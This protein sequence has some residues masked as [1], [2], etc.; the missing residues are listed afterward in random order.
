MRIINK[1]LLYVLESRNLLPEQQYSF[2]NGRSTT[3]ALVI[4]QNHIEEAFRKKESITMVF[5]DISKAYDMSWRYAI[6]KKI[7]NWKIDGRMLC[8]IENF[9][10]DRTL[11]VVVGNTLSNEVTIENGA[12]QGAVLSVT[13]FPIALS[14]ICDG[15]QEPVKIIGYADDWMILT[16][17]NHMWIKGEQIE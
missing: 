6:I 3:A 8:F 9:T 1:R 4:L 11:R 14:E 17:H 5:L 10:K 15:M 16:S 13:L 7:L 12:M 2:K